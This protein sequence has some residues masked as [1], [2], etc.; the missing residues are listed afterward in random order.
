MKYNCVMEKTN[1]TN[2][3][4]AEEMIK[5]VHCEDDGNPY[6]FPTLDLLQ[7]I[8]RKTESMSKQER[9][10]KKERIREVFGNFGIGVK[11]ITVKEGPTVS[12]FVVVP[13]G[14][15]RLRVLQGISEEIAKSFGNRGVRVLSPMPDS[16]TIGIEIPNQEPQIVSMHEVLSSTA[17]QESKAK[18]PMA[19][20]R[21]VSD[22][23]FVADL[24]K[25]P[26]LLIGGSGLGKTVLLHAIIISLLYTRKPSELKFVLVDPKRVEFTDCAALEKYYLAKMPGVESAIV[27]DIDQAVMTLNCLVQEMENRYRLLEEAGVRNINDYNQNLR[28]ELRDGQDEK[29]YR[30][31][32]YIVCMIDGFDDLILSKGK[33]VEIPIVLIAQKARAVGIHLVISTRRIMYSV[34]TGFIKANFPGR[35]AFCVPQKADSRIILDQSGAEELLT[36]GDVLFS[37]DGM[38]TRLQ[39]P[40]VDENGMAR[41]CDFFNKQESC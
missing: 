10:A 22:E 39:C 14:A 5:G 3:E 20:G 8:Q 30:P 33:N 34:I 31:M 41:I 26:H 4:R 18:L 24:T 23:V 25:M 2:Q 37:V 29:T 1:I 17:F 21:T 6:C 38:T 7:G 35:I 9:D 32:P 36:H 16:T 40:L 28:C 15:V 11:R 19:L 27:T 13:Q 12:L